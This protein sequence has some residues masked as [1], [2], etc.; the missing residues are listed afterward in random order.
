[1]LLPILIRVR[2]GMSSLVRPGAS[3]LV[4]PGAGSFHPVVPGNPIFVNKI[5]ISIFGDRLRIFKAMPHFVCLECEGH[6]YAEDA[7]GKELPKA[8]NI[9]QKIGK[10]GILFRNISEQ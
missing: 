9:L 7:D 4:R 10:Q 3:S 1:M 8:A 5:S 6:A 2:P